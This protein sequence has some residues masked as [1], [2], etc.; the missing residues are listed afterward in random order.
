LHCSLAQFEAALA[1]SKAGPTT[2]ERAVAD[3]KVVLAST[4]TA[5][6]E[7]QLG[8]IKITSPI[9]GVVGLL[10]ANPGEIISPGQTILTVNAPDERWFSFTIRE[11]RLGKIAVGAPVTVLTA[12]GA[13]V[14]GRVTELLPLGEF[15]VWRAARAVNDHDLNSFLVRIDP[16]ERSD[17]VQPGMTVWM[18]TS[19]LPH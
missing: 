5:D 7:A 15:A 11:D 9:D 16:M 10:V 8:K 6:I 19:D 4:A 1:E 18:G 3:A 13:H 14:P 2:E 17:S 12:K